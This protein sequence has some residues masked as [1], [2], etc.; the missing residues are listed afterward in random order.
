MPM[1]EAMTDP[2][3]SAPREVQHIYMRDHGQFLS[4]RQAG[5]AAATAF[6]RITRNPGDVI[7][8]FAGVE[9]AT[10]PYLQELF[11]AVTG[12]ILA[13]QGNGRIVLAAN[14]NADLAE[15]MRYVAGHAKR[16]VVVLHGRQLDLI[17]DRPHLA[18]TLR[19]AQRLRPF[20]TAPE[21]AERLEIKPDA[22]TQRLKQLVDLG[23]AERR[24]DPDS[25]RGVRHLY[26]VAD[27]HSV[28]PE[29][30]GRRRRPRR[31]AQPA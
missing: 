13:S 15:T 23:A 27:P 10:P 2:A 24:V 3:D 18:E 28:D 22:A 14:L 7:L 21:L 8:D 16:G 31:T 6:Q 12:L 11:D 4:T 5:K 17:E 26:R 29:H 20:F 1:K 19:E 30:G 9:A 25:R